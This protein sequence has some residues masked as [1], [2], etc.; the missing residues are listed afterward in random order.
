MPAGPLGDD[1]W[2]IPPRLPLNDAY[3]GQCLAADEPFDPPESSQRDLCNCGYARRQC[4]RFPA[5]APDAVRFSVASQTE[6]SLQLVYI[7]ER[8][9]SPDHHG[10]LQYSVAEARIS[11]DSSELLSAQAR[12]FAAAYLR[13]VP[14]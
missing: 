8:D 13:R 1:P 10:L 4:D 14:A 11:G 3:R 9:Y 6:T 2:L 12:A 7:V 5:G